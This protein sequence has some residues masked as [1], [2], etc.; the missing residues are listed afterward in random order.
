MKGSQVSVRYPWEM[1]CIREKAGSNRIDD[2][3]CVLRRPPR[4]EKS[5]IRAETNRRDAAGVR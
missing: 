1:F 3:I 2:E 4:E 5:R